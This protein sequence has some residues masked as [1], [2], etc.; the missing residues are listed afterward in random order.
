MVVQATLLLQIGSDLCLQVPGRQTHDRPPPFDNDENGL[1]EGHG[2]VYRGESA[3]WF[4]ANEPQ[5]VD[6]LQYC[7]S[8]YR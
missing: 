6:Y 4:V 3:S 1:F 7:K 5:R 8:R 2:N